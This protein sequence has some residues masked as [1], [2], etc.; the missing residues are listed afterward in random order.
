MKRILLC[1]AAVFIA[2]PV[3]LSAQD[4]GT[5]RGR[6]IDAGGEPV[7]GVSVKVLGTSWGAATSEDGTFLIAG[8]KDGTYTIRVESIGYTAMEQ[9]VSVS[10]GNQTIADFSLTEEEEGVTGKTVVVVGQ[11]NRLVNADETGKTDRKTGEELMRQ[12]PT[13][14]GAGIGRNA[15]VNTAGGG[16]GIRGG[17]QNEASIRRDGFEISDPV[18]GGA[19][20]VGISLFPDVSLIGVESVTVLSSGFEAEYG[21]VLSGVANTVTRSGRNDRFEGALAYRMNLPFLYGSSQP[22]TVKI[23]G[24]DIDT[25][26]PGYKLQSSGTKIYEFGVGGFIPGLKNNYDLNA[27]TFFLS[28][29]Y[30]HAPHSGGFNVLDMSEEYAAAR[31]ELAR[32]AWGYA[33]TPTNLGQFD[34]ETMVRNVNLKLKYDFLAGENAGSIELG[35]ELGATSTENDGWST[36]YQ[37][38]HPVFS[39]V[40]NGAVVHD[41]NL[42]LVEGRMNSTDDNTLINRYTARFFK[43]L[44]GGGSYLDLQGAYVLNSFEFGKKDE[45][46]EY[47]LFDLYDIPDIV[48]S[49]NLDTYIEEANAIRRETNSTIDLYER[50]SDAEGEYVRNPLTGLYEG[51]AF[52]GSSRNPYGTIDLNFP[53][54]GNESGFEVRESQTFTFKGAYE[55]NF[56]LGSSANDADNVGT[57]FRAGVEFAQYTIRRHSNQNPWES[58]PFN[59]VYGFESPYLKGDTTLGSLLAFNAEPYTPFKGAVWAQTKFNYKTIVFSPGLRFD[60]FNPN[61]PS[62]PF[63]RQ[64]LDDIAA[65]LDTAGNASM[66]F[67]V[68]PRIG[69]SYPITDQSN[70]RVNFAMMF[71]MPEMSLLFDNAY[72]DAIRGNQ[73]FGNPDIKPQK[74]I[75]YDLGYEAQVMDNLYVDV[76]AFYRDIFNQTGVTFIPGIPSSYIL[77]TVQEYGNV[78]GAEVT[79]TRPRIDNISGSLSYTLQRAVGTAS[80]PSSNY[81]LLTR[82]DPYTGES[83]DNPLTEFPLDYDQTHKLVANVTAFW[84]DNEGPTLGGF[85]LLENMDLSFTVLYNTGTPYTRVNTRGFQIGEFNGNRYPSSSNTEARIS[86]MFFLKDLVGDGVGETSLEIYIDIFNVL[87]T[88]G[89]VRYFTTTGNPDQNG[90]SYNRGIGEFPATPYFAERVDA[91]PETYATQQFDQFGQRFYNPYADVNLDGVVTQAEK[92]A[93]YQRLIATIQSFRN[94]YDQPRTVALGVRLRF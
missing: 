57:K 55:S 24:T 14:I 81:S 51:Q 68:S 54:H 5:I 87:N 66:K 15:S 65:A 79:L 50:P 90:T 18:S 70:F 1:I 20:P 60:F 10:T 48:D 19:G 45:S 78:R 88:T 71:K 80:S 85:H 72:G 31:A 59:D 67:Q 74:V 25:T 53:T 17:R 28:G 43:N 64:T 92:Y 58:N 37:Q 40:E 34:A 22:I 8:V 83:K 11:R 9:S 69:I 36:L 77:R 12:S 73:L 21:D 94:N 93:G 27:L 52:V 44:G 41:T 75:I 62:A 26:L 47:G 46:K 49:L 2:V 33:L 7:V 23:A 3:V 76:S 38:D 61:T 32:K 16:I 13:S 82:Q 42:A 30:Q 4:R 63:V 86:R 29:K 56:L 6:I 84:N 91:R 89:P 35:G 39:R